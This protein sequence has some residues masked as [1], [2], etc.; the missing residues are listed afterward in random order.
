MDN[1]MKH[2]KPESLCALRKAI[3]RYHAARLEPY[4]RRSAKLLKEATALVDTSIRLPAAQDFYSQ[5]NRRE[6]EKYVALIRS[7]IQMINRREVTAE[8]A[9]QGS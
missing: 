3:A 4:G 6:A 7:L 2:G 8:N 1:A 5:K 9:P